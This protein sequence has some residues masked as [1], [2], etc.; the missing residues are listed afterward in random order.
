MFRVSPYSC[1]HRVLTISYTPHIGKTTPPIKSNSRSTAVRASPYSCNHRLWTKFNRSIYDF[2]RKKNIQS[3][4]LTHLIRVDRDGVDVVGV[5]VA[6]HPSRARLHDELHR[7][8]GRDVETADERAS[9]EGI[10]IIYL[11]IN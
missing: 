5:R 7:H 2:R 10:F 3:S 8:D 6:V 11:L 9:C 1:K 4:S